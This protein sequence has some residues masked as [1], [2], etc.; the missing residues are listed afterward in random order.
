M[1][2][3]HLVLRFFECFLKQST[4]VCFTLQKVQIIIDARA[5]VLT[6]FAFKEDRLKAVTILF[7]Y[8]H[9]RRKKH[10]ENLAQEQE[11]LAL[12]AFGGKQ[13]WQAF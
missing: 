13:I 6:G 7:D 4:N 5:K 10:S 2:A 12:A 8:W 9:N 1:Q 3:C 11:A